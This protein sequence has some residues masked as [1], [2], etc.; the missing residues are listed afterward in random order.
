[1]MKVV[2]KLFILVQLLGFSIILLSAQEFPPTY[3]AGPFPTGKEVIRNDAPCDLNAPDD[4]G[5]YHEYTVYRGTPVVDGDVDNDDVWNQIPW[6]AMDSYDPGSGTCYIFDGACDDVEG[7][8]GWEDITAWF[9]VLWDDDYLYFAVKKIDNENV[10]NEAHYTD[11]ANIWQDDAYQIVINTND[12]VDNDESGVSTEIGIALFNSVDAA[13]NNWLGIPL[14]LADG[15]G[16]SEIENCDGKAVIGTQV[17][18]DNYYTEVIEMAFIKWEEIVADVPQLFSIMAND[19][20]LD[21]DV[22]AL[23]WGHGIFAS[24]DWNLYASILY[25]SSEAPVTSVEDNKQSGL[26]SEYSLHQ[27]YPN[28]FNPATQISYT[29]AKQEFV[30]LNVYSITGQKIATLV[31]Q[32]QAPGTYQV[33]FNAENLPSG[34]YFY[35]LETKSMTLTRKMALIR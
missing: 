29:V 4:A 1:M 18:S 2:K 23:Q 26:P 21:H 8:D 24:K 17:E 32:N 27:N 28:P 15:A 25:S 3:N 14:E 5:T 34:I 13:Y 31:N 30:Q 16:V 20:D 12:P 10:F 7:Y 22:D 35:Q 19:P 33:S 9:K 11:L 6:T